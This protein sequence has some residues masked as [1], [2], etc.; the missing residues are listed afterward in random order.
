M[1]VGQINLKCSDFLANV[2]SSFNQ[3]KGS[4]IFTDVTLVSDD[5]MQIQAHKLILS[6]G[7][8]YFRNI[9]A[10]KSHPHPMLCLDG[11]SSEDL[12]WII[13]YLYLGEVSVPQSSLQ[14]FLQ[15]ANKLKCFGLKEEIHQGSNLIKIEEKVYDGTSM[16]EEV[17][18]TE[19]DDE[20]LL[21]TDYEDA[22]VLVNTSKPDVEVHVNGEDDIALFSKDYEIAEVMGATFQMD[23]EVQLTRKDEQALSMSDCE[24]PETLENTLKQDITKEMSKATVINAIQKFKSH[25]DVCRIEGKTFSMEK[26]KQ[27]LRPM[28]HYTEDRAFKCNYCPK[29]TQQNVHMME[30]SQKHVCRRFRICLC[31][32]WTYLSKYCY[33]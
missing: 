16:C 25:P 14:K 29:S 2:F 7:S 8:E 24:D 28:Y 32:V 9:L 18:L 33:I 15:V 26:L 21:T 23:E 11:V 6:V 19:E 13:K 31:E 4:N 22:E 3:L 10:D 20:A 27:L 5:N 12:D 30:H 1:A 17:Q